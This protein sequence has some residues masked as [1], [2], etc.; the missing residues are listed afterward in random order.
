M[1]IN[2]RLKKSTKMHFETDFKAVVSEDHGESSERV[3]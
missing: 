2:Q 3:Q 1:Q